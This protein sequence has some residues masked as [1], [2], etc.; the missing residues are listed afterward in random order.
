M[1][2]QPDA[3]SVAK[4][5]LKTKSLLFAL[6]LIAL[7]FV[8]FF[9]LLSVPLLIMPGG[10]DLLLGLFTHELPRGI[11]LLIVLIVTPVVC[12]VELSTRIN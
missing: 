12:Y 1:N 8:A 10:F 6:L 4:K 3:P 9:L 2:Q 11:L 7:I 5:K